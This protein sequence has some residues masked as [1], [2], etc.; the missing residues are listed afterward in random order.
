MKLKETF[1]T[2]GLSNGHVMVSTDENAFSGLVRSNETAALIVELLKH[3]TGLEE[4]TDRLF[5]KF[6]APRE[7]IVQDVSEIL[8]L[9]RSI[10]AVDE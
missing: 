4:I 8:D 7:V 1:L 2:C 6:D 10:G 9:L 3:D 5:A